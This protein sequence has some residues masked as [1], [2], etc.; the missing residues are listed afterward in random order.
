ME[1]EGTNLGIGP[2]PTNRKNRFTLVDESTSLWA[3]AADSDADTVMDDFEF[4]DSDNEDLVVLDLPELV[5]AFPL[6]EGE[7]VFIDNRAVVFYNN[8]TFISSSGRH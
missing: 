5:R 3:K 4:D 2:N 6:E 8:F 7:L 1:E